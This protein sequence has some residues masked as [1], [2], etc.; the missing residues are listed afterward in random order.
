MQALDRD[1]D[2][3]DGDRDEHDSEEQGEAHDIGGKWK[4]EA[5]EDE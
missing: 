5:E 3:R 2:S 1:G 4:K